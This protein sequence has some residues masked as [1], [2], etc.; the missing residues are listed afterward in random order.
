MG[1]GEGSQPSAGL[2]A[3]HVEEKI[4]KE[5]ECQQWLSSEN[6]ISHMTEEP[7]GKSTK[8]SMDPNP[9]LGSPC[10]KLHNHIQMMPTLLPTV[11]DHLEFENPQEG[12]RKY[13]DGEKATRWHPASNNV[14]KRDRITPSAS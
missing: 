14:A 10:L 7:A 2:M 11:V 13:A 9:W 12:A 8:L 4:S 3:V 1:S 5:H 6:P